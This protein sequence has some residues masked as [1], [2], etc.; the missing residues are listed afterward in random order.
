[1][2]VRVARVA[3]L[4]WDFTLSATRNGSGVFC[5]QAYLHGERVKHLDFESVDRGPAMEVLRR[6]LSE[7]LRKNIERD[8]TWETV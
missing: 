1:M 5:V 2:T 3:K 7:A 8:Y 6:R 4:G